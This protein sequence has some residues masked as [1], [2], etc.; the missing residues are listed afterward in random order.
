VLGDVDGDGFKEIAIGA[1]KAVVNGNA[2]QGRLYIV[3]GGSGPRTIDL[4]ASTA[5]LV[6]K[7]DGVA[8][9]DRFGAVVTPVGAISGDG[10]KPNFAVTAGHADAD[11]VTSLATGLVSGKVYLFRGKDLTLGGAT[12][13]TTASVFNGP[14][15]NMH[16]GTFLAPFTKNGP[17]LLIGAQSVNRQSGAVY[18]VNLESGSPSV[19]IF[20]AGGAGNSTTGGNCC[21]L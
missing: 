10:G 18:A 14:E 4:A 15:Y 7:I 21:G 20:H 2:E 11:G 9:F 6:T 17:K 13:L 19:P 1:P 3:K 16:Y 8:Y 12:P 5:D